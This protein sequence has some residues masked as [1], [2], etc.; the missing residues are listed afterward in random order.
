MVGTALFAGLVASGYSIGA[1]FIIGASPWIAGIVTG[2]VTAL[3]VG[4]AIYRDPPKPPA[5][6]DTPS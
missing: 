5:P 1:A 6:P 4:W 3:F 2:V